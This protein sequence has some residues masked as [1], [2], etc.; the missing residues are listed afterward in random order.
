MVQA[1]NG[2]HHELL[3]AP[4]CGHQGHAAVYQLLHLIR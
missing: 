1:A 3:L 4:G 2:L